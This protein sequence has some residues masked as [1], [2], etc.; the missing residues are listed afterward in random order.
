M[1]MIWLQKYTHPNSIGY[2]A[3]YCYPQL[4]FLIAVVCSDLCESESG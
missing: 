2:E 3:A 1:G 4:Y